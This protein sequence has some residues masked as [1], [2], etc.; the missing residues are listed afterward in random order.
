MMSQEY[1]NAYSSIAVFRIFQRFFRRAG[2]LCRRYVQWYEMK[3]QH[4]ELLRMEDRMLKDIGL[5]RSEVVRVI[6]SQ[7]FRRHMF[8]P[9]EGDHQSEPNRKDASTR[10]DEPVQGHSASELNICTQN[11]SFSSN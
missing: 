11:R 2:L 5:S 9:E 7:K 3:R 8:Q 4:E 10:K 1:Q 6:R